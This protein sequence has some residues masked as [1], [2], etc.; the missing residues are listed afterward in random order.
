[1]ITTDTDMEAVSNALA[2]LSVGV[3]KSSTVTQDGRKV[4]AYYVGDNQIRIDIVER[5]KDKELAE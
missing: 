4:T 2:S 5:K 1:M 3:R